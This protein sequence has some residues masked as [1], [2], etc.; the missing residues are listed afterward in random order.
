MVLS[1]DRVQQRLL[2]VHKELPQDRV[3]QWFV[4]L[5]IVITAVFSQDSAHERFVEQNTM[6]TKALSQ[7]RVQHLVEQWVQQ[8][9]VE[10][11]IKALSQDRVQQL[12]VVF[13]FAKLFTACTLL[14]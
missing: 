5:N 6:I 4:A 2:E 13:T 3:Q 8:L 11:I 1:Q 12:F 10:L 9:V 7:D 14:L